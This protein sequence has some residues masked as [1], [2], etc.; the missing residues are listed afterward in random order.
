M[1]VSDLLPTR[2]GVYLFLFLSGIGCVTGLTY[3][4]LLLP[5][6]AIF[7]PAQPGNLTAW[8]SSVLWFFA[9]MICVAI[10]RLDGYSRLRRLSDIWFWAV[11]GCLLLS[12]DSACQVRDV[13]RVVLVKLSG[14]ALY[15]NGDVWWI[16]VYLIVF[17]MIGSR[18][19]VEMRHHLLSCNTFFIAVLSHILACCIALRLFDLPAQQTRLPILLQAGLEMLGTV[20]AVFS[21]S[22]FLRSMVLQIDSGTKKTGMPKAEI[23]IGKS[24]TANVMSEPTAKRKKRKDKEAERP[25]KDKTADV[26]RTCPIVFPSACGD[27]I[28]KVEAIE[29]LRDGELLEKLKATRQKKAPPP[30]E[31]VEVE[32]DDPDESFD[33]EDD[34]A[35]LEGDESEEYEEYEEYE[36]EEYEEEE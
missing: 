10:F 31:P 9:G 11:F 29:P 24:K 7:D 1:R 14:T 27:K 28:V 16:S 21:F 4:C 20:F 32:F 13:L 25:S 36:E 23:K 8:F 19:L 22:L 30:Q 26:S 6:P 17:G 35:L 15:G 5:E 12:A 34:D 18:L 2:W 3:A 33:E